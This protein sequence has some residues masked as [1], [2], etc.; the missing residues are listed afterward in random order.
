MERGQKLPGANR[1][2]GGIHSI[3]AQMLEQFNREKVK[4]I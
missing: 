1:V 2:G 4:Y 3:F